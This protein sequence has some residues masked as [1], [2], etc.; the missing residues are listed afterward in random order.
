MENL[1]L[2]KHKAWEMKFGGARGE[3]GRTVILDMVMMLGET[4]AY[5]LYQV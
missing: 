4:S 2:L 3:V 5:L 1:A